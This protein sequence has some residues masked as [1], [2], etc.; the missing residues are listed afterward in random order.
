MK[1]FI[2]YVSVNGN[3]TVEFQFWRRTLYVDSTQLLTAWH[4][5]DKINLKQKV[6]GMLPPLNKYIDIPVSTTA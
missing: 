2:N 4:V 6:T 1:V 3:A 5:L